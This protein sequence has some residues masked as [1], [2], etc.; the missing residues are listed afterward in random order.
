M[1]E[2]ILL[3]ILFVIFI[4]IAI[5]IT[6]IIHYHNK[7]NHIYNTDLFCTHKM[8]PQHFTQNSITFLNTLCEQKNNHL[9]N[10][11]IRFEQQF[12]TETDPIKKQE[13]HNKMLYYFPNQLDYHT[14]SI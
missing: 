2:L 3:I 8:T 6:P 10:I 12:I 1:K 9:I 5:I 14:I 13:I 4:F 11:F 7:D